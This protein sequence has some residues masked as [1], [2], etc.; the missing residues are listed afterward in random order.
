MLNALRKQMVSLVPN[1][2]QVITLFVAVFLVLGLGLLAQFQIS[3]ALLGQLD[4][5]SRSMKNQHLLAVGGN[6]WGAIVVVSCLSSWHW[7]KDSLAWLGSFV[8]YIT[9]LSLVIATKG[10][11]DPEAAAYRLF[12]PEWISWPT[13]SSVMLLIVIGWTLGRWTN[14]LKRWKAYLPESLLSVATAGLL[15]LVVVASPPVLSLYQSPLLLAL[16]NGQELLFWKLIWAIAIPWYGLATGL[17][18]SALQMLR[19]FLENRTTFG[20]AVTTSV[21]MAAALSY[22]LQLGYQTG[23][24]L[25][26]RYIFP[27]A[28]AYQLIFFSLV[29]LAFYLIT[30]RY[31]LS[32]LVVSGFSV[33]VAMVNSMKMTMRAEPL[34]ITDFVWLKELGLL[35]SFVEK[36]LVY[37]VVTVLTLVL[38]AYLFL[39][40]RFL[41]GKVVKSTGLRAL[42]LGSMAIFVTS[43]FSVFAQEKDNKVAKGIPV[44]SRLNNEIDVNWLG[45]ATNASYKS[46]AYVWTKQLAT[47]I[48][49]TPE[50]YSQKRLEEI[51]ETYSRLANELNQTRPNR[52]QDQTIIYL[53]SESFSD[54]TRL[55]GITLSRDPIPYIRQLAKEFPSGLMLSN[56]YGGGT[57]NM[58]FQSLTGLPMY[59]LSSTVSTINTQVAARMPF[60]PSISDGYQPENRYVIHLESGSNYARQSIYDKLGFD[61]FVGRSNVN[62]VVD[63][64]EYAGV[65]PSD[66]SSYQ[67]VLD[68]LNPEVPQFFSV[69]TMQNHM[70][71]SIGSPEDLQG[72]GPDFSEKENDQLTSYARLLNHTNQATEAFF[73][74]LKQVERP[75]TVVF[76]GDHLPSL[77]P[78]TLFDASPSLQ[79]QTDFMIW[80]NKGLPHQ[81]YDLVN[82]S[83]LTAILLDVTQSK[84]SPYQALLLQV[85]QQASVNQEGLSPE[86]QQIADDLAL[87]QYDLM[88][89]KGYL[90]RTR[91]FF[92]LGE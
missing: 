74:Q 28:V 64:F 86:A 15:G 20:A 34:L 4:S 17:I 46:L 25:L 22:H 50:G 55:P 44:I 2:Q 29:F 40:S 32:T 38:M 81:H 83:D 27:G 39:R 19:G 79:Y 3:D 53:L 16:E 33:M 30:N 11:N 42:A 52:L 61:T 26:G 72:T 10:I 89:G 18:W 23:S 14:G 8:L 68:Y 12:A 6:C 87:V 78:L 62:T 58:E 80:S 36:G 13:F 67:Y 90:A 35:L 66:A 65:N 57:A 43:I 5:V 92:E 63:D 21:V 76:Y 82:S 84:L 45:F 77:Y 24:D 47:P 54:P 9:T 70:P 1:R 41:R 88:R 59:N 85:H 60:I 37:K 91:T 49:P 73:N 48:M 56:G 71:W 51:E 7:L 31:L 75:V 69:L